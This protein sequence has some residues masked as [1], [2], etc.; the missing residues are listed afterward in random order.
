MVEHETMRDAI[1][2]KPADIVGLQEATRTVV[3]VEAMLESARTD[4]TVDLTGAMV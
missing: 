3:V 2:G 4:R 1:I